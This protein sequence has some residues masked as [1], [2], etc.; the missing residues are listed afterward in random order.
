MPS[1]LQHPS[2]AHIPHHEVRRCGALDLHAVGGGSV[3]EIEH[4]VVQVHVYDDAHMADA[5]DIVA[6][7]EKDK[8]ALPEIAE[9]LH[10][11]AVPELHHGIVRQVI[12]EL[13]EDIAC[14]A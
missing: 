10:E 7:T 1:V 13:P 6:R 2:G 5:A 11:L 9:A 8:V 14:K 4:A 3:D 12:A